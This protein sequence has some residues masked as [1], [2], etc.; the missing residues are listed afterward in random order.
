M[1]VCESMHHQQ[2]V[3]VCIYIRE[4]TCTVQSHAHMHTHTHTHTCTHAHT[5]THT[6]MHTCTHTHAHTHI[7]TCTHTCTH[8]H[9]HTGFVGLSDF[10]LIL[11][12]LVIWHITGREEFHLPPTANVWTLLLVNGF[13]GTVLSELLW[14]W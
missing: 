4:C 12:L 7:H 3:Y 2:H 1:C 10:L 11:P 9:T 14:L 5:H 13:V 8:K 6:H